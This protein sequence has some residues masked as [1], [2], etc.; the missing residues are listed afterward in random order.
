MLLSSCC[1]EKIYLKETENG[2]Y[3]VCRA[4]H[5]PCRT[6][7]V[8]CLHDL[9]ELIRENPHHEKTPEKNKENQKKTFP[10]SIDRGATVSLREDLCPE[11]AT[12]Y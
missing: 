10:I 7:S 12:A 9:L 5:L 4:C 11:Y 6:I 8:L 1:K 3:Y 2:A